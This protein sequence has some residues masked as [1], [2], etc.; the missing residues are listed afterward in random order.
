MAN[1]G[2]VTLELSQDEAL[3]LFEWLSR[4][5]DEERHCEEQSE[6]TVLWTLENLLESVLVEPLMPDYRSLL[7]AARARVG[8][9]D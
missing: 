2:K 3:V 8:S 4:T 1:E 5:S 6:Q 9:E 7:A